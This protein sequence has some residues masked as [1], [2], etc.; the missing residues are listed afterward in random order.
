[1]SL[2]LAFNPITDLPKTK[3][4]QEMR[5]LDFYNLDSATL[6]RYELRTYQYGFQVLLRMVESLQEGWW[7]LTCSE[8]QLEAMESLLRLPPRPRSALEERRQT[9]LALLG[10]GSPEDCTPGGA[11]RAL[12]AA[13]IEAQVQE[14]FQ[15]Q[16]L[17]VQVES[18]G[19]GYDSIYQCMER[20][21]E[22]LPAHMEV[23]FEYGGPDWSQWEEDTGTWEAFDAA[24]LTWQQRDRWRAAG[25]TPYSA[26]GLTL[27]E[28][29]SGC[30]EP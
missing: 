18:F 22:F 20:G 7:P 17:L 19:A 2:G 29:D 13:G 23:I 11:Q 15:N 3:M 5:G 9:V 6:V 27:A 26:S 28:G 16:R 25:V 8:S 1:M 14:D 24:D 30:L 4:Y 12:R 10:L 21:R